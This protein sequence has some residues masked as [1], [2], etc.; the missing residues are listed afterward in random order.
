MAIQGY[1]V[2]LAGVHPLS[3]QHLLVEPPPYRH[4]RNRPQ[5]HAA[6]PPD[7]N[8]A[9]L[10]VAEPEPELSLGASL[11]PLPAVTKVVV[12]PRTVS[13]T[14]LTCLPRFCYYSHVILR[15]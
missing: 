14:P 12:L 4:T 9:L 6:S 10:R 2:Y 11:Q 7:T 5:H 15:G 3:N 8:P 1:T 13:E